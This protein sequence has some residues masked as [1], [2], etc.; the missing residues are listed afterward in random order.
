M[1]LIISTVPLSID[2][3]FVQVSPILNKQDILLL[4]AR[5]DQLT[6]L[7]TT[8]P[9]LNMDTSRELSW[10]NVTY[11]QKLA[12]ELRYTLDH[13]FIGRAPVLHNKS[14][15]ISYA[16]SV[17]ADNEEM[18]QHLLN[19]IM[20]REDIGDTY[21]K[22]FHSLLLHGKTNTTEH[23]L[24]GYISLKPPVYE[25][26]RMILGAIVSFI[27]ESDTNP[28]Y[29]KIISEII[30]SLMEHSQLLNALHECDRET[31]LFLLDQ[32]MLEF[33]RNEAANKLMLYTEHFQ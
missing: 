27:P 4:N 20:K 24:F 3:P 8:A 22:S 1:D 18:E 33:Y 17:F 30:G 19:V 14:E 28:V 23:G 13:I 26:G 32:I 16:A 2:Y 25:R 29:A 11:L 12:V 15:V 31:F 9:K 10:T 21:I 6:N 7:K 5:L